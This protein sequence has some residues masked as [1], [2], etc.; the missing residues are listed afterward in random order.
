MDNGQITIHDPKNSKNRHAYM[1]SDVKT[2][3]IRRFSGQSRN[4]LVFKTSDGQERHAISKSFQTS[5][6]ELGFNENIDAL[7]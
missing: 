5:V 6:N 7:V 4:E 1:Q 2:M 3:L